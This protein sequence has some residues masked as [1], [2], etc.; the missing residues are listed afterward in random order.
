MISDGS[1]NGRGGV[2]YK[3]PPVN[4]RFKP[5]QSG[6]PKGRKRRHF[7]GLGYVKKLSMKHHIETLDAFF[8]R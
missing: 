8:R 7:P 4:T 1:G 3:C 5:G 2:G 6:N